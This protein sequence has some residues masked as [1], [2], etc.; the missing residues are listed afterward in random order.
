MLGLLAPLPTTAQTI[1]LYGVTSATLG[2][3]PASGAVK[4]YYVVTARNGANPELQGVASGTQATVTGAYGD[5]LTVQVAAFDAAGNAGPLSTPSNALV[6]HAIPTSGSTT[7]PPTTDPPPTAN[8]GDPGTPPPG[9]TPAPRHAVPFDFTGD[10]ISDLLVHGKNGDLTVWEMNG[11]QVVRHLSLAQL[12]A[13]W[14]LEAPGD[15]DGDGTTDLL[16]RNTSTGQLVVWLVRGGAVTTS[17]GLDLP[18]V[19]ADWTVVARG[20]FDG[21]G[22]DDIALAHP[23]QNLVDLVY[24][25]GSQVVSRE[26]RSAPGPRWHLVA[27]PDADGDGIPELVWEN[28]DTHAL[29]I[30]WISAPGQ[31]HVLVSQPGNFRVIGSGDL[32]GDGREDLLVQEANGLHVKGWLLAGDR[33]TPWEVDAWIGDKHWSYRGMADFDG[34]GSSDP[35]WVRTSGAVELWFT[36]PGDFETGYTTEWVASGAVLVGDHGD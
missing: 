14:Q 1:D 7:P 2:W 13:P 23:Q 9:G 6:F 19:T 10:G 15:F 3:S 4:G 25:N 18:D 17:A 29:S 33:V 32:D 12:P 31:A 26:T 20:D 11:T 5:T 36:S 27:T 22:R 24:L 30:E 28:L 35:F 16:W 21:D 8:S 34:N